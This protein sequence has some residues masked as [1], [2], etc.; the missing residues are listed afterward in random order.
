M[1]PLFQVWKKSFAMWATAMST[2]LSTQTFAQTGVTDLLSNKSANDLFRHYQNSRPSPS[3]GQQLLIGVLNKK[4]PVNDENLRAVRASLAKARGRE[5]KILLIRVLASMYTPGDRSPQNLL[6]ENDIKGLVDSADLGIAREAAL[7]YSRLG[8]PLDRYQVLKRAH[9][10]KVLGDDA[11]Y[12]ELAHGLRLS[13]PADQS[14]MLRELEKAHNQ[15]AN[16]ILAT[17]FGVPRLLGQLNRAHQEDVLRL[18]LDHEPGFPMAVDSFGLVDSVRYALWINAVA[19]IDSMLSGKP[20]ARVIIRR[21][22]S[23]STDPRKILAVFSNPEGNRVLKE[24]TD[25]STLYQLLE[26]TQGYSYSLPQNATVTSAVALFS[27]Q[28]RA[29][30]ATQNKP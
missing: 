30:G 14:E 29:L 26:R 16:E 12:G 28:L 8:Y 9:A 22:S 17:T 3:E 20:Y 6:I 5:D 18:L 21:L 19:T 7:E 27:S 11:Y 25:I 13:S 2:C 1:T 23:P 4:L 10:A 24:T 15:F